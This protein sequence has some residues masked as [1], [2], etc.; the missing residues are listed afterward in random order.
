MQSVTSGNTI[1]V[2][3]SD[4][5]LFSSS[6]AA[7]NVGLHFIN[8]HMQP[9]V[10][11]DKEIKNTTRQLSA[12]IVVRNN[13][14]IFHNCTFFMISVMANE[15]YIAVENSTVALQSCK[16]QNFQGG[17]FLQVVHGF[18]DIMDVEFANGNS[19]FSIIYGLNESLLVIEKATFIS[20]NGSLIYL[21]GTCLGYVRHSV[22]KSNRVF[23]NSTI[24]TL[25]L[26]DGNSGTLLQVQN[27]S[28][29]DNQNHIGAVVNFHDSAIGFIQD[30][31]F[32][33][34]T[35]NVS[36]GV[37]RVVSK[38]AI[39]VTGCSFC[40]NKGTCIRAFNVTNVVIS[41]SKFHSNS[42]SYGG[43][44]DL[45]LIGEDHSIDA[46]VVKGVVRCFSHHSKHLKSRNLILQTDIVH[47]S[48][49]SRWIVSS[50]SFIENSAVGGGAMMAEF[51]QLQIFNCSFVN[52]TAQKTGGAVFL[53]KSPTRIGEC[54]FEGNEVQ[55]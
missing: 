40:L 42:A 26:V 13:N 19:V 43:G 23:H 2:N 21:S 15:T 32:Y 16:V 37:V 5:Y 54:V 47:L 10:D 12:H 22:F 49:A 45:E 44:V 6:W 4:T 53:F 34:N 17:A 52:N 27:C 7:T 9:L 1:S 11:Q 46:T 41:Y 51:V 18:V 20:N 8:C 24:F 35:A 25:H 31:Q 55:G 38:G 28:F 50:C 29:V 14:A 3:V 30:S 36:S 33:S 39:E 48:N